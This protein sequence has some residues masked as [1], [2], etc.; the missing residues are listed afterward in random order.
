MDL[1]LLDQV[2]KGNYASG[3]ILDAGC[4][5]GRNLHWFFNQNRNVYAL[6]L[7]PMA[8]R[9]VQ[10]VA[11]TL[12][13]PLPPAQAL[14]GS[15]Q[16]MT[17]AGFDTILCINVLQHVPEEELPVVLQNLFTALNDAGELFLKV[18]VQQETDLNIG[19]TR[20]AIMQ[21]LTSAGFIQRDDL[22]FEEIAG[23]GSWM[24]VRLG[25]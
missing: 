17:W 6:D 10:M 15:I 4:G 21:L 20:E 22:R 19:V 18:A 5:E 25:K 11:N 12:E 16:Q 7:D 3:K 9:M 14:V 24:V 2:M 23:K 1:H 13:S 8:I